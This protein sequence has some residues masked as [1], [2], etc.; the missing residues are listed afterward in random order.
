M[1]ISTLFSAA[2]AKRL[3]LVEEISSNS[4]QHEFNGVEKLKAIIGKES[5]LFEGSDFIWIGANEDVV[6]TRDSLRWY[7]ARSKSADRTGR[8]EYRFYYR[9]NAVTELM[10]NKD[11]VIFAKYAKEERFL[12]LVIE[13]GASVEAA[14]LWLFGLDRK[15]YL[16]FGEHNNDKQIETV[17]RMLLINLG[18]IQDTSPIVDYGPIFEPFGFNYPSTLQMSILAQEAAKSIDYIQEPDLAI[19]ELIKIEF[20][21]YRYIEMRIEEENIR[22]GFVIDGEVD[23]E[24]FDNYVKSYLNRRK[25]R[26]GASLEN[27]LEYIFKQNNL[28][29]DRQAVTE[30]KSKPDF[31]FPG[32]KEY[33][34][35]SYD[36]SL[37]AMLA[38][39]KSA[40]DRWRQV[41]SEAIRIKNKHLFTQEPSISINQT[42]E[43]RSHSLIL[44]IPK[45]IHKTYK[46]EQLD[47]IV[48]LKEF[49]NHIKSI[50]R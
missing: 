23:F 41:L 1:K 26:A 19:L 24:Y 31:L 13:D 16:V 28:K 27:H 37:L 3:A 47:M 46:P 11:L 36:A 20:D 50:Q 30:N 12:V 38:S 14:V 4:N 43:M 48:S 45:D 32:R 9:T 35:D 22:K 39:K 18:I 40:K 7:D 42:K 21:M 29:F 6:K 17:E 25:S 10:R 2:V 49:I 33:A 44:V 15:S 8:S 34:E 5:K